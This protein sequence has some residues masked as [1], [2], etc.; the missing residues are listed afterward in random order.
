[1]LLMMTKMNATFFAGAESAFLRVCLSVTN[2]KI[3][4]FSKSYYKLIMMCW[5]SL[6][7]SY[8]TFVRIN[9]GFKSVWLWYLY[10]SIMICWWSICRAQFLNCSSLFRFDLIPFVSRLGWEQCWYRPHLVFQSSALVHISGLVSMDHIGS[11]LP[12]AFDPRPSLV[13]GSFP[14]ISHTGEKSNICNQCEY[15]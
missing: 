1:M 6:N 12:R 13:W 9:Y 10:G 2:K 5:W 8:G 14:S 7:H 3:M 11:R 4:P 15:V